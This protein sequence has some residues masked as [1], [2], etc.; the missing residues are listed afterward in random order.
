[1]LTF[2]FRFQPKLTCNFSSLVLSSFSF[3]IED[4]NLV[5]SF[6]KQQE[7][8][9]PRYISLWNTSYKAGT[10]YSCKT[11]WAYLTSFGGGRSF[12][13]YFNFFSRDCSTQVFHLPT[14]WLWAP[15]F[16]CINLLISHG[17]SHLFAYSGSSNSLGYLSHFSI[18][19]HFIGIF[20]PF[21]LDKSH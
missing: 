21:I 17:I 12:H 5:L 9:P 13:H 1:M 20:S 14:G 7:Q 8:L 16:F 18:Y 6:R 2:Y 10:I 3:D 11:V 4:I 19:S 15:I